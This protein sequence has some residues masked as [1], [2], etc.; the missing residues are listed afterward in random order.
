MIIFEDLN[1]VLS[2]GMEHFLWERSLQPELRCYLIYNT[3]LEILFFFELSHIP[4]TEI[5]QYQQ[6]VTVLFIIHLFQLF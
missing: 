2:A 5:A 3:V 4:L 6:T 1:N